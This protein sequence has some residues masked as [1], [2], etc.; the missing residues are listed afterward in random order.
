MRAPETQ[1]NLWIAAGKLAIM[2]VNPVV[3]INQ[4]QLQAM[5]NLH[6]SR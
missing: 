5:V 4:N 2:L 3:E 1:D 6:E